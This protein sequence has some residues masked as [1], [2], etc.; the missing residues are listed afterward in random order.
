MLAIG[1][2]SDT[3]IHVQSGEFVPLRLSPHCAKGNCGHIGEVVDVDF[4]TDRREICERCMWLD[5]SE[6]EQ[7]DPH[8]ERRRPVG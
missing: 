4:A 5:P 2:Y 7:V 6:H 1:I 3:I 8:R